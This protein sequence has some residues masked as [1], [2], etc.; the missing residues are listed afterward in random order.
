M[1]NEKTGEKMG[2]WRYNGFEGGK[3]LIKRRD[4]TVPEWPSMVLGAR[5]PAAPFA[6][7]A[8]AEKAQQLGYDRAFIDDMYR[9]ADEFDDYREEHGSG[10]PEGVPHRKD[11][12]ATIAEMRKGRNA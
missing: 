11:D 6:L 5:D 10:D 2:L 8:Y 9:L 1:S 12:P 3:Y 7:R 4:G